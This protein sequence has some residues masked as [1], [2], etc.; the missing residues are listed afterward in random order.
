MGRV[1]TAVRPT[2][3]ATDEEP[4]GSAFTRRW[5]ARY[6]RVRDRLTAFATSRVGTVVL[7]VALMAISAVL[8]W[9][10]RHQWLWIDE[11]L[12]AGISSHPVADIPELLRQDGSP[13]LYYVLLHLWME[14]VGTGESALHG[15]SYVFALACVPAAMWAGWSLFGRGVGWV[16]ALL[17][18]TNPFLTYY[19]RE[20]RMYTLVAFLAIIATASFLHVYALGRR[21]HLP[22]FVVA[23]TLLLYTHNW[24]LFFVVGGAVALL[25]CLWLRSGERRAVVRD[26]LIGFGVAGLLYLPWVPTLLYQ[27][28]HTGAPW[29]RKPKLREAISELDAVLG[30]ERTL[31][32]LLLV[33]GAGIV[34][35]VR[36]HR[37]REVA[38]VVALLV[39]FVV[40]LG[41][42]WVTSQVEPNWAT[43]YFATIVG[44]VL[45][46]AAL[47]LARAGSQ[48]VVALVMILLFW[49]HPLGRL[50]G[51]RESLPLAQKSNVRP[52]VKTIAP[53]LRPGDLVVSTHGEQIP[54]VRYY[55]GDGYRYA[56]A[57]G[58]VENPRI[59][60]WRDVVERMDSA[61]VDEDLRPLVDALPV[62]RRVV[63]LGPVGELTGDRDPHWFILFHQRTNEW[64]AAL[65]GD[66]RLRLVRQV[67]EPTAGD[68]AGTSVYALVFE[69]L[70]A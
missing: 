30:D 2:T 15:F 50:T 27:V 58:P 45:L 42:S 19:G 69:K 6:E 48:G 46:V 23:L 65:Q 39:L 25:P 17:T 47:G 51:L 18:A 59:F 63:L 1:S 28:A 5:R 10:G 36:R 53:D 24:S 8:R 43:R 9:E 7:F 11:G 70:S 35:L 64:T 21:R 16:V 60:D 68:V 33:A 14:V 57:T 41:L 31:V 44:A 38:D 3:P 54:V 32:A 66:P 26:A 49:T 4:P 67:G 12:S 40:P 22:V 55:L 34:G 52:V 29:S 56:T 61:S 13:P 62:G 37:D 20:A